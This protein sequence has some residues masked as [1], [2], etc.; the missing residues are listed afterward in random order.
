MYNILDFGAV[1]NTMCTQSIQSAIDECT[2]NGGGCVVIPAGVYISGTIYLKENVELHLESGAVLKASTDID[3][4]N[5]DDAYEQNWGSQS[6]GWRAK[7]LIIALECDNV[8]ITG[9]GVIDGSGDAFFGEE[10]RMPKWQGYAWDGGFVL[11]KDSQML[12]PGQLICFVEATNVRVENVTI[13]N[14][15]CWSCFMYG[16]DYVQVRGVKINNPICYTNTDGLDIDCC[17][18]VTISDCIVSTGDDA[19]AIRCSGGKLKNPK[20][21]EY[22]TITNCVLASN[23]SLFRIGVGIGEIRNVRASNLS[24]KKAAS[25]INYTTSYCGRGEAIIEDVNFSN[26]SA[27]DVGLGIDCQVAKGAVRNVTIEN[28]RIK[29]QMGAVIKATDEG[30]ISDMTIRN[31]DMFIDTKE[32]K[33]NEKCAVNIENAENVLLD[34]LRIFS[35][36]QMWEEMFCDTDCKNIIKR[37]CVL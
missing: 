32:K 22:I 14:T 21:C 35:D 23:S 9:Y 16:C 12:R 2:R 33:I 5:E 19:I 7:H 30:E 20:P 10:R 4:Y 26:I 29:S 17:R 6:E 1:Q 8:S 13:Q 31:V 24:V 3:D 25:L 36:S 18:Y 27:Y 34:G 11:A 28:I 37:N 15:P